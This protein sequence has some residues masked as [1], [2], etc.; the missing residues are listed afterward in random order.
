M[1][2]VI[3]LV[4]WPVPG[5]ALVCW[6]EWWEEEEE[7]WEFPILYNGISG[8]SARGASAGAGAGVERL[9]ELLSLLLNRHKCCRTKKVKQEG[10]RT[11][12]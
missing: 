7:E 1:V 6:C 9:L 10:E 8:T 3:L 11:L 2:R 4:G 5:C 12:V